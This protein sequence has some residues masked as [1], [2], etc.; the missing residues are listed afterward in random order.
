MVRVGDT[1]IV[2]L[3]NGDERP[4]IVTQVWNGEC[5]NVHV[6]G[7]GSYD[8]SPCWTL[9]SVLQEGGGPTWRPIY[10]VSVDG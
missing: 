8:S 10:M 9:T 6:F 3:D 2:T 5:V 7:D 1:V 4:A